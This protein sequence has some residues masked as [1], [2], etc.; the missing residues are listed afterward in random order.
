MEEFNMTLNK[1]LVGA[2]KLTA[3]GAKNADMDDNG[4]LDAVDAVLLKRIFVS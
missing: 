3:R 4:R 2:G 1:Y